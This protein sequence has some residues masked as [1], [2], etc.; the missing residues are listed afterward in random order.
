MFRSTEMGCT[1]NI[2]NPNDFHRVAVIVSCSLNFFHFFFIP[3]RYTDK[4]SL[5][6]NQNVLGLRAAVLLSRMDC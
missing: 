1:F 5:R 4:I 6:R 2:I 3:C